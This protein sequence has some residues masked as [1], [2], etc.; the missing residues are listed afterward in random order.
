MK[1]P[2]FIFKNIMAGGSSTV[3]LYN[4]NFDTSVYWKVKNTTSIATKEIFNI[5]NDN[6]QKAPWFLPVP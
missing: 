1:V 2:K 6:Y 3:K 4:I 5:L